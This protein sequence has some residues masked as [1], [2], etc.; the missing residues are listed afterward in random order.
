MVSVCTAAL[1]MEP[2]QSPGVASLG[3]ALLTAVQHKGV[4]LM[5]RLQ[6]THRRLARRTSW[7]PG[8]DPLC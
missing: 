7:R 6:M 4:R 2:G 5:L 8:A 1:T 3:W